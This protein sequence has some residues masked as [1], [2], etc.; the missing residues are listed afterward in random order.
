MDGIN[1]VGFVSGNCGLGVAARTTVRILS[2]KGHPLSIADLIL[3]GDRIGRDSSFDHLKLKDGATLPYG[4]TVLH[5]NPPIVGQILSKR[6]AWFNPSS[7]LNLCVPFWELPVLPDF[8]I[9]DLE[10]VHA[11]L[12]PSHFVEQT[13]AHELADRVPVIRHYP[14]TVFLPGDHRPDRRRFG[15]PDAG[16]LFIMSFEIASDV[17]RKNPWA[18]MDAFNAAFGRDRDAFLVVKLNNAHL[19][20]E[21]RSVADRLRGYTADN[22]RILIRDEPLPYPEV[23]G[24]YESCDVFVS[25]HRSEGLGL[26]PLEAMLLGKPVIATAWSGN[27]DYMTDRNSCLV[28]YRLVPVRSPVYEKMLAGKP[29]VWAEPD[30]GQAAAWMRRLHE[31]GELRKTIGSEARASIRKRHERC[32]EANAFDSVFTACGADIR[33]RFRPGAPEAEG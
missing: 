6:P 15:L 16:T 22:S 2:M 20:A 31:E 11:V 30:V 5:V 9:R 27:M 12:A 24:L 25:L 1:I 8:W 13:V 26:G 14:Q 23:I 4:G 7:R 3:P 28:N 33:P 17:N 19:S 21:C 10:R 32:C 18:V 29:A